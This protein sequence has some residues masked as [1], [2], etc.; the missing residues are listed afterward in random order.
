M[1]DAEPMILQWESFQTV[2]YK[3][4]TELS[5]LPYRGYDDPDDSNSF[6]LGGQ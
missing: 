5:V 2:P 3:L 1:I 6:S 4:K